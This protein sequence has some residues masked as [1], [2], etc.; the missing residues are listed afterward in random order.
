MTNHVIPS[1]KT[2]LL[3]MYDKEKVKDDIERVRDKVDLLIVS[4]HWGTENSN[5]PNAQQKDI[6]TYLASLGVDI[7]IGTHTHTVQPIQYIN[8]TLVFYSLG[9]FISSQ[10]E[11]DLLI[12]LMPTLKITKVEED[13]K[14]SIHIS[15]LDARLIYTYYKGV[16]AM[17]KP[18]TDHRV[19]PFED[20][21]TSDFPDYKKYYDEYKTI[22]TSMDDSI[23]VEPINE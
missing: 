6:A 13:G 12:G 20:L 14:T 8:G 22:L 3:D 18:H 15:D 4:M 10:L 17:N 11:Y 23:Y 9:N 19:I 16:M 21:T 5:V 7:I 1:G 2:Y